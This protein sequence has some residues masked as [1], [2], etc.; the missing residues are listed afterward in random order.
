[1]DDNKTLD[2]NKPEETNDFSVPQFEDNFEEYS[3]FE[4]V[5]DELTEKKIINP[6]E[7]IK[8][9]FVEK[10][11]KKG[12][13]LAIVVIVIFALITILSLSAAPFGKTSYTIGD[14]CLENLSEEKDLTEAERTEKYNNLGYLNVSGKTLGDI[15]KEE[16]IEVNDFLEKY[17]LPKDMT[18]DTYYDVAV[19][20][21]P[22]IVRAE[23]E[24]TDFETMKEKFNIP[25][26]IGID[27][28]SDKLWDKLKSLFFGPQYVRER[29]EVTEYI[30]W[31]LIYD[32]LKLE[33]IYDGDFEKLKYEYNFGN[34]ITIH[35]K[36]KE[37]RPIMEKVQIQERKKKE[38]PEENTDKDSSEYREE[39]TGEVTEENSSEENVEAQD[40][41][42][43]NEEN[44][45]IPQEDVEIAP[46]VTE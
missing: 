8:D 30:P 46:E 12:F 33:D 45:E 11:S 19:Y 37:V 5:T 18:K 7:I 1:M 22:V 10:K 34:D 20:M 14:I 13:V 27:I 39:I 43:S 28:T 41:L 21:M 35:T 42:E 2:N 24:K 16:N 38:N 40:N 6:K 3:N 23:I 32:E 29:I 31:G 9:E 4:K 26:S 25:D 44:A 15:C 36:M 17:G